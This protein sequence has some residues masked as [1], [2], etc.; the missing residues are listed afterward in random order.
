[1]A[2]PFLIARARLE[3]NHERIAYAVIEKV[4]IGGSFHAKV[5]TLKRTGN[6]IFMPELT[7]IESY[8]SWRA[9]S[10]S[11]QPS[12]DK[13]D[14]GGEGEDI[15]GRRKNHRR[16]TQSKYAANPL[17]SRRGAEEPT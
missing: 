10:S 7:N 15:Q 9:R 14:C 5:N 1:M 3:V 13:A 11:L 12:E 2:S 17:R 16:A 8:E 4:D 6:E